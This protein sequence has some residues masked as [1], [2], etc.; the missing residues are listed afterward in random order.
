[1]MNHNA[2]RKKL[3]RMKLSDAA[4]YLG[5]SPAKISRLI[6]AGILTCSPD[7]LDKRRELVRVADLDFLKEQ[8]LIAEEEA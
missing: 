7:L 3:R 4:A 8:S 1:M 6:S 5:V 2:S